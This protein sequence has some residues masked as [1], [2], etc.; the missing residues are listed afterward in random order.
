M[1]KDISLEDLL[2]DE[3]DNTASESLN[4]DVGVIYIDPNG[5][6]WSIHPK[7]RLSLANTN[8]Q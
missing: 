7:V 4:Q 8:L 6:I 2:E 3:D 5:F 1:V